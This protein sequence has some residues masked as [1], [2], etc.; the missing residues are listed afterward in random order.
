MKADL[1][2]SFLEKPVLFWVRLVLGGIFVIASLDK[3]YR[4]G[5]FAQVIY[6][7]QILPDGLINVTAIVL[8][9]LELLLGLFLIFGLWL[10]GAVLLTNI[11]LMTFL[12]ALVFNATRG[13]NV[14]CG[15]FVTAG[16]GQPAMT[17]YL[18]RDAAFLFMG[19]CLFV[20]LLLKKGVA[21]CD[22]DGS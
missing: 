1:K 21:E 20:Q 6:N 2:H 14:H 22:S 13:L 18:I 8:P 7:Y 11:L 16:E 3:I 9:W 15:C 17:W 4:P 5:D 10:P 19:A 12:G